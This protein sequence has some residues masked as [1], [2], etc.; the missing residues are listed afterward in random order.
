[1]IIS[2]TQGPDFFLILAC[3]VVL[4]TFRVNSSVSYNW[5]IFTQY[6]FWVIRIIVAAS[7]SVTFLFAIRTFIAM[8]DGILPT[9][10]TMTEEVPRVH[11]LSLSSERQTCHSCRLLPC[12][13]EARTRSSQ[14]MVQCG[15]NK[16][17]VR[18]MTMKGKILLDSYYPTQESVYMLAFKQGLMRVRH[19][20][21]VAPAAE[22]ALLRRSAQPLPRGRSLS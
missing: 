10:T 8:C 16:F 11:H 18:C 2:S 5:T 3:W 19:F 22:P 20:D 7:T 12:P 21:S 1:M 17:L 4:L 15:K 9:I 13:H 14:R 6:S